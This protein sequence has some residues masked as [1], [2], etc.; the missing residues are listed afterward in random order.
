MDFAGV[1]IFL[2][3][4]LKFGSKGLAKGL[5]LGNICPS[6]NEKRNQN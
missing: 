1:R 2:R 5:G 6:L 3:K 4:N